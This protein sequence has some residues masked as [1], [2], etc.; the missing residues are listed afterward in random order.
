MKTEQLIEALASDRQALR[1]ASLARRLVLSLIVGALLSAILFMAM[2]GPRHDLLAAL[3][4]WRFDAKMAVLLLTLLLAAIAATRIADP[5]QSRAARP[6]LLAGLVLALTVGLE[7]TVVA[8]DL[9]QAHLMGSNALVCL[10]FIPVLSMA[11][12][13]VLLYAMRDGAPASPGVAGA[14]A[15]FASFAVGAILYGLHCFDDSPL[16]V[17]TWYTLAAIPP[18]VAGALVGRRL[19]AW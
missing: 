8:R 9:W 2:L 19:L 3:A 18:V 12:L 16:F 1:P 5:S 7:L 17:A 15:G 13:A 6:L 14:I 11:P 10:I 4:T